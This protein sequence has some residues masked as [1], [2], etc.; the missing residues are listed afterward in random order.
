MNIQTSLRKKLAIILVGSALLQI[1]VFALLSYTITL[2]HHTQER[3][4]YLKRTTILLQNVIA[5]PLY[6]FSTSQVSTI[7]ESF[8]EDKYLKGLSVLAENGEPFSTYKTADFT[9]SLPTQS[10]PIMHNQS[11][12]GTLLLS[13]D[14]RVTRADVHRQIL[15]TLVQSVVL[16]FVMVMVALVLVQRFI[17]RPIRETTIM[18]ETFAAGNGD[19]TRQ[20][21]VT[22]H[23][24]IGALA[25][26]FNRFVQTL[27]NSIQQV[28]T[29]SSQ[30]SSASVSLND[31]AASVSR[32]AQEMNQL[33][34]TAAL[35]TRD[36]SAAITTISTATTEMSSSIATIASSM[37]ELNV[38]L[39][40]VSRGIQSEATIISAMSQR[41]DE[42]RSIIAALSKASGTIGQVVDV[43][44]DIS[45][46]IKL[47]ALNATIEAASAGEAGKGF[48]VVARE[49]KELAGKTAEA[50][51]AV[52]TQVRG[53]QLSTHQS[54][55]A[56]SA[57]IATIAQ[58]NTISQTMVAAV[59]QQSAT[60]A[61]V[62][63][64]VSLV[65][66]SSGGISRNVTD[67]AA[68]L[69][70]VNATIAEVSTA[71]AHTASGIGSV[72]LRADELA[73][74]AHQLTAVTAQFRV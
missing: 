8:A 69:Q 43:I 61:L 73:D 33:S 11:K 27:R 57:I 24:E 17:F 26:V 66:T 22:Q 23:D 38:S 44:R 5:E 31:N 37:E 47:L 67:S 20:L 6:N 55:D 16:V 19:L 35:T 30:L 56:I 49:V 9:P 18:L 14:S 74:L 72:K 63:Q 40:E 60:V 53:I 28:A 13:Y 42:V 54:V 45:D 3:D 71:A 21:S 25:T 52:Q 41:S 59:E 2:R 51:N 39:N 46:Q 68:N 4:H 1:V 70:Q 50:I 34:D 10:S 32:T 62:A 7:L 36:T 12:I 64:N 65:N 15:M 58:I 29:V 48:A